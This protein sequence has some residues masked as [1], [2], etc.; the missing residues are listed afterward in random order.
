[1]PEDAV[2]IFTGQPP[3]KA[4]PEVL[5][6]CDRSDFEGMVSDG[7][8]S[9]RFV[10]FWTNR[11]Y[12][13][14]FSGGN[15]MTQTNEN[16][17]LVP[18]DSIGGNEN[19][20]DAESRKSQADAAEAAYEPTLAASYKP[21]YGNFVEGE[22]SCDV[23]CRHGHPTRFFNL[24][25]CHY[26]ACDTCLTCIFVGF[27]LTRSWRLENKDIWDQNWKSVRGYRYFG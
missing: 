21:L 24:R 16:A 19:V 25:R 14:V 23:K 22:C 13:E 20:V 1:M 10:F 5:E 9:R 27:D 26:V 7:F 8:R 12:R 11:P 15:E 4:V 2:D 3:V 17:R 6:M 18:Q